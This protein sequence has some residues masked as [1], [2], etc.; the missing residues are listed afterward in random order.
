MKRLP[1]TQVA[2]SVEPSTEKKI[3]TMAGDS[4]TDSNVITEA[5][6]EVWAKQG[7]KEKATDIYNKLS[8]LNPSKSAYFAAKIEN[9]KQ[10]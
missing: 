3:E 1:S 4:V 10:S 8:L 6:A 2:A 5:M 9:L 7:N